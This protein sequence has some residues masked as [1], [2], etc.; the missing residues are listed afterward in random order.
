[1]QGVSRDGLGLCP[2]AWRV[3]G[4]CLRVQREVL[5]NEPG[6]RVLF[7]ALINQCCLSSER[8]EPKI[9]HKGSYLQSRNRAWTWRTDLWLP[10]GER[11]GSGMDR[12]FG[13]SRCKLFHLE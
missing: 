6:R 11:G 4:R 13:V 1:M 3:R 9:W 5:G 12:E 8:R 7:Q 2:I 10:E